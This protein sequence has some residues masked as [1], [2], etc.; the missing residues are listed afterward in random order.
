MSLSSRVLAALTAYQQAPVWYLGLSGGLDSCVLLHL[1]SELAKSHVLPPVRA[2]HV[3]HGLQAVADDWPAHCATLCARLGIPLQVLSVRVAAG[4][5][6]E[7]AA[8]AAR[9]QALAELLEP[10]AVLVTAQHR[11]DQA[12]TLLFRL[13]RGAGVRGLAAMPLERPLGQG[14]LVRPLLSVSRTELER[15]A[16]QAKLNWVEDPSNQQLEFSRNYLRHQVLPMLARRWPQVQTSLARTAAHMSEAQ[17]LLDELAAQDLQQAAT[18]SGLDWL[19]LPSLALTPLCALSA[20]RQR[21]LL[22]YWL[23]EFT[24]LPDT[25]HW[26]SWESLRDA[27]KDATPC[28]RLTQGSVVRA[29]GRIWFLPEAWLSPL[30]AEAMAWTMPQQV[31]K[32]PNNGQLIL[33]GAETFSERRVAYRRGGERLSQ[34]GHGSAELKRLLNQFG[35]PFFV[36]SRLPLLFEGDQLIAVANLPATHPQGLSLIWQPPGLS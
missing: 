9:Y 13:L 10:G 28:W 36:R 6:L 8:R 22:R 5:S 7:A 15:Y 27:A 32:L 35:V 34:Q 30:P 14:R 29:E 21:N 20:P 24:P 1:L 31:L 4:A 17:Q 16:Q 19:P 11:D 18:P 12:E 33:Q 3:H 2:V 23:A 25:A 26:A